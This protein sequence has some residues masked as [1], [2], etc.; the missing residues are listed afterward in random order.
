MRVLQ[1]AKFYPPECGGIE[2]IVRELSEGLNRAGWPTDV[3]CAHRHRH[4]LEENVGDYRVVRA[5]S[6]GTFQSTSISPA[7]M[8]WARRLLPTYDIVHVHMPNP[9]AA[10]ALWRA[11]PKAR[12]IVHWHSDVVR[13]RLALKLYEPLQQWLLKRADAVIVTSQGY[14]DASTALRPWRDKLAVVPLGI[15]DN[16][17]R[18][19]PDRV[20]ALRAAWSNRK[21]IFALGRMAPYKGFD[22]LIEAAARL[23]DDFVVVVGGSGPCLRRHRAHVAR[24]ALGEKVHFV[25]PISND[26]LSTYHQAADVFC[27]PSLTRAEA[28]GVA[29]LE[30]MSAGRP[31]VCSAIE[32]SGLPWV[33]QDGV[34]GLTVTPGSAPELADAL[35]RILAEPAWAAHLGAGARQRFL[36]FFTGAAMVKATVALYERLAD[37]GDRRTS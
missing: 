29:Q 20:A 1:L 22:V 12:V 14:A 28:F 6:Y 17:P 19:D 31:V 10:L 30:A 35:R 5:G 24:L 23:P 7:L 21:I 13:Q 4:S 11:Q 26:D 2:T 27:M 32:G 25:G 37:S 33:N 36:T 9:L 16:L 34:T 8:A 18:T 3:L 15:G